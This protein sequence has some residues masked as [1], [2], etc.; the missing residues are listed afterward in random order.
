MARR[1][2]AYRIP[3]SGDHT[4]YDAVGSAR[5]EI[6]LVPVEWTMADPK[7]HHF[8]P[9]FYLKGWCDTNSKIVEYSR[10]YKRVVGKCVSPE[11][12][13]FKELLYTL[14]GVPEE[15]KQDLEKKYM[16]LVD[17]RGATALNVLI[18]RDGDK[19]TDDIR[20]DWTRF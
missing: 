18:Q 8:S 4:T 11:Y 3:G 9:V 12:T 5:A 20:A 10:P 15:Q 17:G 14:D 1:R 16:S 6:E 13:G 7:K 2:L 19:L